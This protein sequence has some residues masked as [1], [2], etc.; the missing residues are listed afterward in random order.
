M[1]NGTLPS[2]SPQVRRMYKAFSSG[3]KSA[4]A[5]GYYTVT[6]DS[7]PITTADQIIS[8]R[9]HTGQI[10]ASGGLQLTPIHYDSGTRTLYINYYCP[11]AISSSFNI[12][13]TVYYAGVT[14]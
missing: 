10:S 4:G 3:T 12:T 9:F 11:S 7:N 2:P 6:F 14:P 1:A 13:C 8:I 5:K